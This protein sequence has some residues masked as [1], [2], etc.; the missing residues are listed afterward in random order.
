MGWDLSHTTTASTFVYKRLQ[1]SLCAAQLSDSELSAA[2]GQVKRTER[3]ERWEGTSLFRLAAV[4]HGKWWS[5]VRFLLRNGSLLKTT[6]L[7]QP[8]NGKSCYQQGILNLN[9]F[10]IEYTL[11]QCELLSLQQNEGTC[12]K[13]N[14]ERFR[15][16]P[17]VLLR[18]LRREKLQTCRRFL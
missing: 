12:S 13:T 11:W 10:I 4:A 14:S 7:F 2:N 15:E 3:A 17:W 8:Y 9:Y 5:S 6:C 16:I 18:L 1:A